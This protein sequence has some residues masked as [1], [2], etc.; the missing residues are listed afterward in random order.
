MPMLVL[1]TMGSGHF[2]TLFCFSTISRM[3][4]LISQSG[5]WGSAGFVDHNVVYEGFDHLS[6][7]LDLF[8]KELGRC[9]DGKF[10]SSKLM[11]LVA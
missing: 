1:W 2:E 6:Y 10:I 3:L 9:L 11:N 4:V 5:G 8:N 7:F